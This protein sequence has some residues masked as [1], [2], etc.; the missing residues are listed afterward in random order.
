MLL[1]ISRGARVNNNKKWF[2]MMGEVVALISLPEFPDLSFL[3][4]S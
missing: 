2:M 3:I 1:V 4:L